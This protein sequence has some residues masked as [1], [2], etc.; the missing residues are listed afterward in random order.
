M[1]YIETYPSSAYAK[2]GPRRNLKLVTMEISTLT[3][4]GIE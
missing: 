3:K 1:M 4:I 2:T